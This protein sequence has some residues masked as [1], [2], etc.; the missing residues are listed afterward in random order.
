MHT[1]RNILKTLISLATLF[2]LVAMPAFALAADTNVSAG[3]N[4]GATVNVPAVTGTAAAS[5]N[6]TAT[7]KT[8]AITRSE[9]RADQEIDRRTTNL[10]DLIAK[11]ADIKNLSA[12][13]KTSISTALGNQVTAL[14]QLKTKVDADT[15]AA[16]L[17]TDVQSVT[18]SYRIYALILPQ[19]RIIIASDRVVTIAGE[20]QLLAAKFES[21]ISA[22]QSAGTDM[23]AAA[24]AY[25][26][27]NA[28]VSDAGTQA[29]AAVTGIATLVPDNGDKT[30]MASNTAAL[31]AARAK[32]AASQQDLVAARK[33][34]TAI[35][36]AVKGQP[37]APVSA[38][39][40][41][42][43]QTTTSTGTGQ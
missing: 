27:F 25:A 11:V 2:S 9:G 18:S 39:A 40:T 37:T 34:A 7:V 1:M 10:N 35:V 5:A 4:A 13:D 43:T 12:S 26:D 21:R 28:K 8:A 16:I 36:A 23:T 31:K 29:Q 41:T 20:M 33:D 3:V 22:A 15:D 38:S 6:V 19:V 30:V 17:K 42:T 24:A 14:A 32:V